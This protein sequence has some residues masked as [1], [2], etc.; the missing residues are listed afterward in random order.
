MPEPK[1]VYGLLEQPP[2]P[3]AQYLLMKAEL[4]NGSY[5]T[6]QFIEAITGVPLDDITKDECRRDVS[7]QRNFLITL[8]RTAATVTIKDFAPDRDRL[9][10]FVNTTFREMSKGLQQRE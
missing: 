1:I 2:H 3:N 8:A 9:E 4:G 6:Q 10:A 5:Q 7:I